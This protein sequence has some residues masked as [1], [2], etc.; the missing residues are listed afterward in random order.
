MSQMQSYYIYY[1]TI[2]P[3]IY[4]TENIIEYM[5]TI[6]K[7]DYLV[8]IYLRFLVQRDKTTNKNTE[9]G[10]PLVICSSSMQRCLLHMVLAV[11]FVISCAVTNS[12]IQ[13]FI[14]PLGGQRS[15]H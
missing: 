12:E 6:F 8:L 15:N 7:T 1:N 14:C 10:A 5:N 3:S 13:D 4:Y 9:Q 11:F 2:V